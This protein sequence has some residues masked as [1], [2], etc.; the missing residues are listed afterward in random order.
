MKNNEI[1]K[2]ILEKSY[3]LFLENGFQNTTTRMIAKACEIGT[4]RLAYYFPKKQDI[5]MTLYE[6]YLNNLISFVEEKYKKEHPVVKSYISNLIFYYV[7]IIDIKSRD[8][9]Y[10]ILSDAKTRKIKI[11]KTAQMY[12]RIYEENQYMDD[13]QAMLN[14]MIVGA[15]SELLFGIRDGLFELNE[16]EIARSITK[17]SYILKE[18]SSIQELMKRAEELYKYL[19]KKEILKMKEQPIFD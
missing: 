9:L 17:L 7:Y 8:L 5:L 15:E 13:K 18:D 16:L 11:E 1:R 12:H 6:N 3:Y 4:G 10:D 2:N 14:A 19:D